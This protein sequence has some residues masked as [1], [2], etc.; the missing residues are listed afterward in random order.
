VLMGIIHNLL[1]RDIR[2]ASNA[3]QTVKLAGTI[4]L[5]ISAYQLTS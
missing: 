5:V 1:Q 4:L 3:C 2:N